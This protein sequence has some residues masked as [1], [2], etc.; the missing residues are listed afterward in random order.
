MDKSWWKSRTI[1]AGIITIIS[2]VGALSGIA[3]PQDF[4][5]GIVMAIVNGIAGA[6]VIAGR[7]AATQLIETKKR[8][9]KRRAESAGD[10]FGAFGAD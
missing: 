1:W 3:I 6:G 4:I 5:L 10:S 7:V 8:K 9:L 2:S